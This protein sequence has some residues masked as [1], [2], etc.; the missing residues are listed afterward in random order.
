MPFRSR[1][2]HA[3]PRPPGWLE[4]LRLGHYSLLFPHA[5]GRPVCSDPLK[6]SAQGGI[7]GLPQPGAAGAEPGGGGPAGAGPAGGGAEGLPAGAG[8]AG[9]SGA[10]ALAAQ[11]QLPPGGASSGSSPVI[12]AVAFD[13][14][15]SDCTVR[16][17]RSHPLSLEVMLLQRIYR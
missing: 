16:S 1:S 17:T 4:D 3:K 6:P 10:D 9:G 8:S 12:R 11:G 13:G 15:L 5:A 14:L 2:L 7:P